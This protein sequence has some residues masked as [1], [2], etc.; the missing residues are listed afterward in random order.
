[1]DENDAANFSQNPRSL[2]E[3]DILDDWIGSVRA[4]GDAIFSSLLC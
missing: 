4:H 1:M 2:K 3:E